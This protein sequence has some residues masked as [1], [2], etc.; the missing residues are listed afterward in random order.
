MATGS[1]AETKEY[2]KFGLY[3]YKTLQDIVARL[4]VGEYQD[5]DGREMIESAEFLEIE[6]MAYEPP[7]PDPLTAT[8]ASIL[9]YFEEAGYKNEHGQPIGESPLPSNL[10]LMNVRKM[11]RTQSE[12]AL[13]FLV[14][15]EES[16]FSVPTE[17]GTRELRNDRRSGKQLHY[18]R[19]RLQFSRSAVS[20][21]RKRQVSPCRQADGRVESGI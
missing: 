15:L 16:G 12:N 6:K 7:V 21:L 17:T 14:L 10:K 19:G 3:P 5:A 20:S 9:H 2:E 11:F 4:Q 1:N 18:S 13:R 8:V